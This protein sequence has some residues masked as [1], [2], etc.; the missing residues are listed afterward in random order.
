MQ[1]YQ[2]RHKAAESRQ[3]NSPN[4]GCGIGDIYQQSLS[5]GLLYTRTPMCIAMAV[6]THTHSYK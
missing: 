2:D 5:A 4:R 1:A 3:L 6:Y